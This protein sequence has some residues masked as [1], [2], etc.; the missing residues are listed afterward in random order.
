VKNKIRNLIIKTII[1]LIDTIR[2]TLGP[3]GCCIYPTTCRE[4]AKAVLQQKFFF[5]A[6]PLIIFRIISCNPI[7]AIILKIKDK[8][9]N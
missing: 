5:I 3:P 4:Y 9:I 2:P 1:F 7:T 8:L 6:I